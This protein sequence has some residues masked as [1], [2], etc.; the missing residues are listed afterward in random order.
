APSVRALAGA[1][2]DLAGRPG[3]RATRQEAADRALDVARPLAT[4]TSA[5]PAYAA[6]VFAARTVAADV[7]LFAGVDPEHVEE[8][9]LEGTGELHVP[10]P[11]HAPRVP[12][13]RD[14]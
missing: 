4:V 11:P 3:A 9:L 13:R 8:A 1:L 7:M 14:R 6:A 10:P 12:F 2:A 5:D